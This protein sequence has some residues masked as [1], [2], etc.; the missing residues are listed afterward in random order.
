[1]VDRMRRNGRADVRHL[2]YP[3]AGHMLFPY[4]RPSDVN[5]PPFPVDV[6]GTADADAAAH[7]EAWQVVV[8][9]LRHD[10]AMRA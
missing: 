3:K 5:V 1:V 9:H 4:S 10:R 8:D 6:G 2:H 7:V